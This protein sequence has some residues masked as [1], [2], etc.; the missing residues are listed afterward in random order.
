MRKITFENKVENL[1][2]T[3]TGKAWATD[4]NEIKEVVNENADII[5]ITMAV[6]AELVGGTLY[7]KNYLGQ[8][9]YQV[10]ISSVLTSLGLVDLSDVQFT[11]PLDEDHAPVFSQL[12]NKFVNKK[13]SLGGHNH[14]SLYS[15]VNHNHDDLYLKLAGGEVTG[16]LTLKNA[17]FN[18]TLLSSPS[19]TDDI[20]NVRRYGLNHTILNI[21]APPQ[22]SWGKAK[23]ATLAL[24]RGD[25]NEYFLDLYNMDYGSVDAGNYLDYG[26]PKM[27]LRMQKRRTGVYTL[28]SFEYGDGT[29]VL[30]VMQLYP[31]T[32]SGSTNDSFVSIINRLAIGYGNESKPQALAVN[33]SGY[34]SD[35]ITT[36]KLILNGHSFTII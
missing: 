3:Y 21:M 14:D 31:S 12:L 28:F 36:P 26:N 32:S 7:F 35:T 18:K 5:T 33:G 16:S 24:V 11:M 29:N 10:D 22:T 2:A 9:I 20:L 27:G 25:N 4:F 17:K 13:V 15:P 8:T 1:G 23:E 19:A 30:P 6:S 34:F